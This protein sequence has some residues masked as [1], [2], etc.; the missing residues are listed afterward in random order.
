MAEILNIELSKTQ[1]PDGKW[2]LYYDGADIDFQCGI[3]YLTVIVNGENW[4]S[5]LFS[6]A[7]ITQSVHPQ[8]IKD[9]SHIALRFYDNKLKQDYFKNKNL[10]DLGIVNPIDHIIPF[11]IDLTD[12]EVFD[13]GAI[14]TKIVCHDG[15]SEFD[16][17]GEMNYNI[18]ETANI[19]YHNGELL[20]GQ[21]MCGTYYL[22]V[23]IGEQYFYSEH[24]K[25]ENITN[26][27]ISNI[28]LY[29]E[30]NTDTG[31]EQIT[32]EDGQNII[33]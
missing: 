18:N 19:L 1:L 7:N 15:L 12:V 10:C 20:S 6:I 31:F 16:L 22:Q 23:R 21:L 25:V 8:L 2:L 32:T 14:Q 13:I 11:V 30:S 4:Y 9:K 26:V 27:P 28:Y 3:H 24:F 33:L 5:E 17:S 29:T